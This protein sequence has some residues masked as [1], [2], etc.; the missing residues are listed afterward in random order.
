MLQKIGLQSEVLYSLA[1][2][3]ITIKRLYILVLLTSA[4]LFAGCSNL[5]TDKE[6]ES[7][8]Q[9]KVFSYQYSNLVDENTQN[10]VSD[11]L[12]E[13]GFDN[14]YIDL[15]IEAV[16][17]FNSKQGMTN[18]APQ[19]FTSID[20]ATVPYDE[21]KFV[22]DWMD[23][24]LPYLDLNC[25]ITSFLL[26]KDFVESENIMTD[27]NLE[28]VFDLGMIEENPFA[29]LS[30]EDQ[31]KFE[32]IFSPMQAEETI[33]VKTHAETIKKEWAE[34]KV[35]FNNTSASWVNVFLHY[36]ETE[37]LFVGH[38]GILLKDG[39]GYIFVEKLASAQP[40]QVSKFKTKEE[41]YNVLMERYDTNTGD[42]AKIASKPIIMEND[43][44]L[45]H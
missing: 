15:F 2:E 9:N 33:D 3:R 27:E 34:R 18:I 29:A 31:Q 42:Y 8:V 4:L 10:E 11:L 7:V 16:Q 23:L 24:Q 41:L 40:F 5:Y 43:E 36:P 12:K 25:R 17:D 30:K 37:N 21:D 38:S 35:S 19:G 22:I 1:K 13:N 28:L 32:N 39:D 6:N 26:F 20:T 44:L 14:Q 45:V